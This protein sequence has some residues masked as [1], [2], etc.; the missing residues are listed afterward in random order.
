MT[1]INPISLA[2][3]IQ[4]R[5]RLDLRGHGRYFTTLHF[6]FRYKMNLVILL[7]LQTAVGVYHYYDTPVY[8]QTPEEVMFYNFFVSSLSLLFD[9]Y[10][11]FDFRS[12]NP[13]QLFLLRQQTSTRR[14]WFTILHW[15]LMR[16]GWGCGK[17][18]AESGPR[19]PGSITGSELNILPLLFIVLHLSQFRLF[20]STGR[21]GCFSSAGFQ[22]GR[23][24][25]KSAQQPCQRAEVSVLQ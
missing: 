1:C 14:P 20:F 17:T 12:F 10:L 23:P 22:R 5:F 7:I 24:F 13:H 9:V 18:G 2:Q 11:H 6:M 15:A 25:L 16:R 19:W 3:P 21:C 4:D 8:D